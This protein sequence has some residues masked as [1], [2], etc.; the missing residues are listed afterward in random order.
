MYVARVQ[1]GSHASLEMEAVDSTVKDHVMGEYVLM[2]VG[3]RG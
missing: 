1:W 2:G 3:F